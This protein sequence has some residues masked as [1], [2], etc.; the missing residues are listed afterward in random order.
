MSRGGLPTAA[1]GRPLKPPPSP[2]RMHTHG[3][4]NS[5][6]AAPQC[7][8]GGGPYKGKSLPVTTLSPC[9]PRPVPGTHTRES[10]H[11]WNLVWHSFLPEK[12]EG[13]EV[14]AL[15]L[16]TRPL[17]QPD[18]EPARNMASQGSEPAALLFCY[19]V[20]ASSTCSSCSVARSPQRPWEQCH[21]PPRL[22]HPPP[23]PGHLPGHPVSQ[24]ACGPGSAPLS[25]SGN[26]T[27]RKV[28]A[29]HLHAVA[30]TVQTERMPWLSHQ[31]GAR[32]RALPHSGRSLLMGWGAPRG[33]QGLSGAA[34]PGRM[35]SVLVFTGCGF[36]K[37]ISL[38]QFLIFSPLR[39][40][41]AKL[42]GA[43]ETGPLF[44]LV[45]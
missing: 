10:E 21:C 8:W 4:G 38:L 14:W 16:S 27:C 39:P 24:P 20:W 28:L 31:P 7:W 11:I 37:H 25:V 5:C 15:V 3:P 34:I 35:L 36:S 33:S 9:C 6:T 22:P 12:P 13:P 2:P 44:L 23:P 18:I 1:R 17:I 19:F 30:S 32:G 26:R 40:S 41:G 43:G 42:R 29:S 45:D